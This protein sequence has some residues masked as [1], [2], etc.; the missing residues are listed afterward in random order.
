VSPGARFVLHS[1]RSRDTPS[2][3][4]PG[5][6]RRRD[7]RPRSDRHRLPAAR[8]PPLI[9]TPT[10]P[11]EFF[12][13]DPTAERLYQVVRPRIEAIGPATVKV[14]R[15]QI[16]F[17]RRRTFAAV[18]RPGQCLRRPTPPL[19]LTVFLRERP[20]SP[21]FKQISE[22]YPGRFSCHLELGEESDVDE[23]VA[24]WLREGWE[25]AG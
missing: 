19:V 21:R 11:E 13:G 4:P 2:P 7:D 6:Y 22:P 23:E 3:L 14:S 10:T 9:A 15:S 12:A 8:R 17:A 18:W 1:R 16:A 20:E 5:E 24:G 25:V